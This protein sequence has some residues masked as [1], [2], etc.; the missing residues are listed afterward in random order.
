MESCVQSKK[1]IKDDKMRNFEKAPNFFALE[2]END[3][4]LIENCRSLNEYLKK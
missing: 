2:K 3:L 1:E 4:R